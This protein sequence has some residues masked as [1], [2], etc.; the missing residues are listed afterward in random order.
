MEYLTHLNKDDPEVATRPK[1]PD[2]TWTAP[3]TFWD[4]HV[5]YDEATSEEAHALKNKILQ[6]KVEKAIGPHYD[7]FW[8]VDVAR[9]DVFG[10]ILSWFVQHHGSLS[11]LIF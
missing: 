3:V 11:A 10:K 8:E 1:Y 9:V 6:L 5:Y 4:F 2:L 7:L